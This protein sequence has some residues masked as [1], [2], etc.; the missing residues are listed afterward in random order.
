MSPGAYFR[1]FTV[2]PLNL[3]S[4]LLLRRFQSRIIWPFSKK[5]FFSYV[6]KSEIISKYPNVRFLSYQ[7]SITKKMVVT[8]IFLLL[9]YFTFWSY[10]KPS[11]KPSLDFNHGVNS[12]CPFELGNVFNTD[13]LTFCSVDCNWSNLPFIIVTQT[14]VVI[15]LS[16]WACVCLTVS[17]PNHLIRK[18]LVVIGRDT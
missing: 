3:V 4:F 1:N 9:I 16:I 14:T 13:D 15:H 11:W 5:V 18:K 7:H 17:W 10:L 8:V 2:S 12:P 6:R